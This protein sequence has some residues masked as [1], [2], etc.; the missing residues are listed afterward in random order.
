MKL[1]STDIEGQFF[2]F[3]N[4]YSFAEVPKTIPQKIRYVDAK[5]EAQKFYDSAVKN[6]QEE[7]Q[8]SKE[9]TQALVD[10]AQAALD[11]TV[12]EVAK[13][14]AKNALSE[15]KK[16]KEE[17][18][19]ASELAY[20]KTVEDAKKE[21][22]RREKLKSVFMV[23]GSDKFWG[24]FACH[25]DTAQVLGAYMASLC[26]V[27]ERF[28]IG[29]YQ[30]DDGNL[31]WDSDYQNKVLDKAFPITLMN[32]HWDGRYLVC[33]E[34]GFDEYYGG[35]KWLQTY[36]GIKSMA[37]AFACLLTY[38]WGLRSIKQMVYT[39]IERTTHGTKTITETVDLG[40]YI[41]PLSI[42]RGEWGNDVWKDK[43]PCA[44]ELIPEINA[45]SSSE[46]LD[47]HIML[48]IGENLQN[49]YF[50]GEHTTEDA[51]KL[52][53]DNDQGYL[54]AWIKQTLGLSPSWDE[55]YFCGDNAGNKIN[56]WLE[57]M[58]SHF[59][60]HQEYLADFETDWT[61]PLAVY[62]LRSVFD[63][64]SKL[65]DLTRTDL[66]EDKVKMLKRMLHCIYTP[67]HKL[68]QT[69]NWKNYRSG[70]ASSLSENYEGNQAPG[71]RL[72]V[73]PWAFVTAA[74]GR[75]APIGCVILFNTSTK[76][77]YKTLDNGEKVNILEPYPRLL[78]KHQSLNVSRT[79]SLN[80]YYNSTKGKL[81]YILNYEDVP[82]ITW[83]EESSAREN[84]ITHQ[85]TS[86]GTVVSETVFA[87][88]TITI[89]ATG[90]LEKAREAYQKGGITKLQYSDAQETSITPP[91]ELF[92]ELQNE[93][94][95]QIDAL[96]NTAGEIYEYYDVIAIDKINDAVLQAEDERQMYIMV[97]YFEPKAKY[98]G[99]IADCNAILAD[100]PTNEKALADLKTAQENLA[101]LEVDYES[102]MSNANN[103]YNNTV[104]TAEAE[105][106]A[107][108]DKFVEQAK[109]DLKKKAEE[110]LKASKVIKIPKYTF[111]LKTGFMDYL[112]KN[113]YHEG[114]FNNEGDELISVYTNIIGSDNNKI[115]VSVNS[116]L[117]MGTDSAV[118]LYM[119]GIEQHPHP[120][121]YTYGY[122]DNPTIHS[123]WIREANSE[124]E[125]ATRKVIHKSEYS[126]AEKTNT[127]DSIIKEKHISVE[128]ERL[129]ELIS[130]TTS[131]VAQKG[132]LLLKQDAILAYA[133]K[134]I[135]SIPPQ[136]N[137]KNSIEAWLDEASVPHFTG[138]I[139]LSFVE[140]IDKY[141]KEYIGE[142]A[143]TTYAKA[144]IGHSASSDNGDG[145]YD[146]ANNINWRLDNT[147]SITATLTSSE[148][149]TDFWKL[150]DWQDAVPYSGNSYLKGFIG[151][152]DWNWK[153]L[154][155]ND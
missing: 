62:F 146:N 36:I 76:Y 150:N 66:D 22:E 132:K 126:I 142:T 83:K 65:M 155:Y 95:S 7:L 144:Y 71:T 96:C 119:D 6:A 108:R 2:D 24:G 105:I 23:Y 93:Y 141:A 134:C 29:T 110:I 97:H 148:L 34:S 104:N 122:I 143:E 61:K 106:Y 89:K 51:S 49:L 87:D 107:E 30:F 3:E 59:A 44:N 47:E 46:V 32:T 100:D 10:D 54:F 9:M 78:Y 77:T 25:Y 15:A 57:G 1:T 137:L 35:S 111:L 140:G 58:P 52:G 133:K 102:I 5:N 128:E 130:S 27:L 117:P 12:D 31:D 124:E 39:K 74:M 16:H 72:N 91:D 139:Y 45:T 120:D 101:Q 41:L 14:E 20:N 80:I 67:L 86:S 79:I 99:I 138:F 19:K 13:E 98:E 149:I 18:D 135:N 152:W 94:N 118:A 103:T 154:I 50:L 37:E 81:D 56:A 112:F 28:C 125:T 90:S 113:S 116:I 127:N 33:T 60:Q 115:S 48:L 123:F 68:A 75:L 8:K 21:K 153:S 4:S 129:I 145:I 131:E 121:A 64:D 55:S 85:F 43:T 114:I 88:S 70:V 73:F 42:R 82:E 69:K 147:I 17:V 26:G 38:D 53:T 136:D 40:G 92:Q 11:A 109:T 84:L 151:A 63:N